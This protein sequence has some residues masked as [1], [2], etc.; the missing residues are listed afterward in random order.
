MAA[1]VLHEREI[2]AQAVVASAPQSA[3]RSE[4]LVRLPR[5]SARP[6]GIREAF[7]NVP[8]SPV[9]AEEFAA[10]YHIGVG[11]LRQQKR[12]DHLQEQGRGK[13]HVQKLRKGG[14]LYVWRDPDPSVEDL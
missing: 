1:A 5:A 13:V 6:S 12:F 4:P 10:R 8:E 14:P 9:D 3:L 7:E 11:T 2:A